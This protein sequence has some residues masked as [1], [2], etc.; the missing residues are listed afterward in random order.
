GA[1]GIGL[2]RTEHMFLGD[3]RVLIERAILAEPGPEREDAL[4][5]LLPLQREDFVELLAA[6]DDLPCTIRLLD[7]P[8]HELLPDHAETK[9]RVALA[10]E[11]GTPDE[12]DLRLLAAV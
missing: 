12:A 6:M 8:L 4:A 10:E 2:C 3:R 7:P 1:A 11:R 9:V 5:A